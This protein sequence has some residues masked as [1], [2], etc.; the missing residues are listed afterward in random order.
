MHSQTSDENF[1]KANNFQR[2]RSLNKRNQRVLNLILLARMQPNYE[3]FVDLVNFSQPYE[4]KALVNIVWERSV[5]PSAKVNLEVLS[6]KVEQLTPSEQDYDSYGV[7]PA[8]YY[9]TA[10]LTC[11]YGLMNEEEYDAVAIA[12]ISQGCVV[13]LI[14]YQAAEQELDN[15]MIRE[16]PLMQSEVGFLSE[17]IDWLEEEPLKSLKP[18]QIRIAALQKAKEEGVTNTGIDMG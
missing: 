18:N 14:E 2:I 3:L 15:D 6:E 10:L 7:Y 4:L 17:L 1:K 12:K 11:I 16:H 13:H 8:I 5:Q 9:C